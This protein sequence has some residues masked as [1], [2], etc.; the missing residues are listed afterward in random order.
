MSFW[1]KNKTD[2]KAAEIAA[3]N[4]QKLRETAIA[5]KKLRDLLKKNGVTLQI[6]IAT[7]GDRR[8]ARH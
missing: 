4:E 7:G 1:K 6:Y 3:D 2:T 8:H 5:A